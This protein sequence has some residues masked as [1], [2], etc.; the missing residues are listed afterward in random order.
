[1]YGQHGPGKK[2]NNHFSVQ[3]TIL[4]NRITQLSTS[5][6]YQA[7]LLSYLAVVKCVCPT[8]SH[9]L[10]EQLKKTFIQC[11]IKK[12]DDFIL[13]EHATYNIYTQGYIKFVKF[14]QVQNQLR[15]AGN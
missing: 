7:Y 4:E 14:F 5:T 8:E 6:H 3:W 11:K 2:C 10:D 13:S 15:L 9:E 12:N 1:M